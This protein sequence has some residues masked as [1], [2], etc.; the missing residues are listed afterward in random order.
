MH[1]FS[2]GLNPPLLYAPARFRH[3]S[4]FRSPT[5]LRTLWMALFCVKCKFPITHVGFLE[6]T[7]K[8]KVRAREYFCIG[9]FTKTD[10]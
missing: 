7:G 10:L 9:L 1:T 5:C 8:T 2:P 6:S 4:P 3:D